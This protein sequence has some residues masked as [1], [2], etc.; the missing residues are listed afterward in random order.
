MSTGL[1]LAGFANLSQRSRNANAV[2]APAAG[3]RE[4]AKIWLNFGYAKTIPGV[5][6]AEPTQTFVSLARGIPLDQVEKFDLTKQTRSTMATLR[7]DQNNFLDAL[8]A[9]A[10]EIK[11]GESSIICFDEVSGLGIEMRVRGEGA[12]PIEEEEGAPAPFSFR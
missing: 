10:A 2:D 1:N 4:E 12:A 8:M 9:R 6:G 7:R 5:D 3:K 11:P